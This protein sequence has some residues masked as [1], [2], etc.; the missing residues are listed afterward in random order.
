MLFR[1]L[2]PRALLALLLAELACAGIVP[3]SAVVVATALQLRILPTSLLVMAPK[4]KKVAIAFL[5]PQDQE[6]LSRIFVVESAGIAVLII[7]YWLRHAAVC[8]MH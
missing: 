5:S 6:K 1:C 2:T 8:P 4:A 3:S 7:G